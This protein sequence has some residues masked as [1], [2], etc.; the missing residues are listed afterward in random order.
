MISRASLWKITL[1]SLYP[2]D[3]R[4]ESTYWGYNFSEGQARDAALLWIAVQ[5]G[6]STIDTIL[7]VDEISL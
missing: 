1:S 7:R 4:K 6:G 2:N 3:T 5:N